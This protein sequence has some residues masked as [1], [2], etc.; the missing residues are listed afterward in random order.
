MSWI[1]RKVRMVKA[2]ACGSGTEIH[3]GKG[4]KVQWLGSLRMRFGL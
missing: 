2:N 1:G 3:M 4:W